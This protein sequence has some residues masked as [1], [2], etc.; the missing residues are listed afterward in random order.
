MPSG[1][2]RF[3]FEQYHFNADI[4]YPPTIDSGSLRSKYD[5]IVF[6]GGAIPG[7]GAEGGGRFGGGGGFGGGQQN[8]SIPAEFKGRRGRITV[9]KSIPELKRF[10]EAGGRIVT[11]G[12]STS[13]AYHLQLPVRN[14]LVEMKQWRR[15]APAR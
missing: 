1:W 7:F 13:L 14:A 15:A 6:V 5:V 10:L 4:I 3:I 8:D 9:E 12:S 11:I 2:I